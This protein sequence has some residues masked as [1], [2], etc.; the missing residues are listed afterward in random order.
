M[1]KE[2]TA[3]R[4]FF[5]L[6]LFSCREDEIEFEWDFIPDGLVA[7]LLEDR[8]GIICDTPLRAVDFEPGLRFEAA[9]AGG[10]ASREGD[11]MRLPEN[12]EVAS[13]GIGHVFVVSFDGR[14]NKP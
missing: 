14:K 8:T 4:R 12:G 10:D 7:D 3:R 1:S 11:S 2:R 13:N 9:F 5:L 6:D